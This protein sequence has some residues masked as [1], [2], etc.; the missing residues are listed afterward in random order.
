MIL[1][2]DKVSIERCVSLIVFFLS[3][4]FAVSFLDFDELGEKLAGFREMN[5]IV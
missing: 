5:E 3:K 2:D 4:T 1:C